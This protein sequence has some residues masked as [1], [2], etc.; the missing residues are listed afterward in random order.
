MQRATVTN[1]VLFQL[2]WFAAVIGTGI[3]G[4]WPLAVLAAGVLLISILKLPGWRSDLRLASW[5]VPVGWLLDTLWVQSG[6][7]IFDDRPF[8]PLWIALL[9]FGVALSVNHS[10]SLLR[11]YPLAGALGVGLFA[12]FSYLG[13]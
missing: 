3:Y 6:I 8:A 1:A 7:M 12:P 5:L 4:L 11:D 2:L 9:W 10:L 13:G